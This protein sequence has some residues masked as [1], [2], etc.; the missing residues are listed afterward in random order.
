M[1]HPNSTIDS[2]LRGVV[3]LSLIEHYRQL[4][5]AAQEVVDQQ[6]LAYSTTSATLHPQQ[7]EQ[8]AYFLTPY[9]DRLKEALKL[10]V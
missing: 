5:A 7:E 9:I 3:L 4:R 1:N 6:T 10:D 8:L 2:R